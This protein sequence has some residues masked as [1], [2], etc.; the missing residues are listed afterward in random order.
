M[1]PAR[2]LR[3]FMR[4]SEIGLQARGNSV[5]NGMKGNPYF[6]NPGL[7][8][9]GLDAANLEYANAI[10]AALTGDSIKR[11]A[12]KEAKAKLQAVLSGLAYYVEG[13][14]M[15]N[16]T[17]L[18]SSGFAVSAE[19][20]SGA[21]LVS[22]ENFKVVHGKNS[23]EMRLSANRVKGASTYC[24]YFGYANGD[25]MV[26]ENVSQAGCRITLKNLQPGKTYT[27]Y[28]KAKGANEKY[29]QSESIIKVVA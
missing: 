23:G 29:V 2:I 19:S 1:K 28:I 22:V 7:A 5:A 21:V 10:T 18:L 24:F 11:S 3:D 20:R 26:W 4:L 25:T 6:P 14:A 27:F 16:R 15:G 8:L 12:K 13:V 17:I 9:S